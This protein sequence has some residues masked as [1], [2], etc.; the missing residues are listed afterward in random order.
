M[1]FVLL[2]SLLC[3]DQAFG[4]QSDTIDVPDYEESC[5]PAFSQS[6]A[7]IAVIYKENWEWPWLSAFIDR[8]S[9]KFFCG[10]SLISKQ[11][12][13]TGRFEVFISKHEKK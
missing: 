5:L 6:H 13:L 8:A 11:H 9:G 4:L 12:I 10:G 2:V 1:W 7:S 3:C